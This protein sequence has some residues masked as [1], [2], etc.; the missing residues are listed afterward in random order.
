MSQALNNT[1]RPIYF[2]SCEWG[3]DE[4]WLWMGE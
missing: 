3:V 4:P 2:L 1:G